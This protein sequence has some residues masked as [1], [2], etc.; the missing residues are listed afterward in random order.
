M[1]YK[2]FYPVDKNDPRVWA[3]QIKILMED[4][5]ITQQKLA[6]ESGVPST[7]ISEWIGKSKKSET[8]FREPGITRF[9]KVAK[10]LGVSMDYL[11]G[12]KECEIPDDEQIHTITGLS[13]PAIKKL[14][15]LNRKISQDSTAEEEKKLAVLNC[16]ISNM[17]NTTFLESLYGYL[18]AEF[19]FP[20]SKSDEPAGACTVYSRAPN[21]EFKEELLLGEY[22]SEAMLSKAQIDLVHLKDCL[23]KQKE[24]QAE[25]EYK[26][27]EAEHRDEYLATLSIVEESTEEPK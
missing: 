5:G 8:G 17:D 22:L 7:T 4:R 14:K 15:E 26:K 25:Y 24:P 10:A 1:G 6:S 23:S 11:L 2:K 13:G 21:G 20:S 16:L 19:V 3:N 18:L 27:W 12:E 9:H